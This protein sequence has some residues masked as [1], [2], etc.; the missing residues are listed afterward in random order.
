[1][2]VL[3]TIIQKNLDSNFFVNMQ[4][5][6]CFDYW[7]QINKNIKYFNA[8]E[9][10]YFLYLYCSNLY[11]SSINPNVNKTFTVKK[12]FYLNQVLDNIFFNEHLK[13][14]F[15]LS[16]SK[17]QRVYFAFAKLAN[18]YR[19][20]KATIKMNVDL[21]MNELNP[22]K[23]NVISIL[24]D[25]SKY[26]FLGSDLVKVIN[27]SLLNSSHFFAEPL[28]PKNPFN[29][30]PFNNT[31]LYNIYFHIKH[32]C[33][34]NP[35][36][37]HL[38]FKAN[39]DLDIF[40]YENESIIRDTA[41][42]NYA[43]YSPPS[44]LY[45]DLGLMLAVNRRFTKK[46]FIHDEFP[47]DKL[48]DVFRPYFHLFYLHRYGVYGTEKRNESL[49]QLK[50][51]LRAFVQYNPLF[52]RKIYKSERRFVQVRC[53][54][55]NTIKTVIKTIRMNSFNVDHMNFY[56]SNITNLVNNVAINSQH[57]ISFTIFNNPSPV[58]ED[59]YDYANDY[60]DAND[61]DDENDEDEDEDFENNEEENDN[62][63]H[64]INLEIIAVE[65]I[66]SERVESDTEADDV[67]SETDSIS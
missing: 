39:F 31:T 1:M 30:L 44:V 3:C 5:Q 47:V 4:H 33:E 24:Q 66:A 52:G 35:I 60:D 37:F 49:I 54:E 62:N 12:F 20:K 26:L 50:T 25:G 18:I 27:S 19:Y 7:T 65:N 45:H 61:E 64:H 41:I 57:S 48:V 32:N 38:F 14:A 21:Y 51:K 10:N 6:S 13:G 59:D 42:K 36:L 17:A 55:T 28:Q 15:L 34:I 67:A 11:Y 43:L 63:E 9:P 46:L 16:F 8:G 22:D 29:N 53:S 2:S 58:R 23:R 40:L 56:K